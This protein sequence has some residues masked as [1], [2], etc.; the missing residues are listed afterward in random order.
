MAS[1]N[2]EIVNGVLVKYTG[3]DKEVIIPEGVIEI[4]DHCFTDAHFME[5]ITFPSTLKK[6]GYSVV[7]TDYAG[8]EYAL[9]RVN[10]NSLDTWLNIEFKDDKGCLLNVSEEM[11]LYIDGK[12]VTDLVIP[13]KYKTIKAYSFFGYKRLKSVTFEEGVEV[14]EKGAFARSGLSKVTLPNSVTDLVGK[15]FGGFFSSPFQYCSELKEI[16]IPNTLKVLPNYFLNGASIESI[17]LSGGLKE[18]PSGCFSGCKKLKNIN[19]P[20]S[21]HIVNDHAFYGCDSIEELIFP[22]SVTQ[23]GLMS[24]SNIKKI[25]LPEDWDYVGNKH[26][27][28]FENTKLDALEMNEYDNAYYIGSNTNPYQV[29]V[30]A[31]NK[32]IESCLIHQDCKYICGCGSYSLGNMGFYKCNKIKSLIIPNGVKRIEPGALSNCDSLE[33]VELPDS[34]GVLEPYVYDGSPKLKFK[35]FGVKDRII[36]FEKCL[37]Q[38][39]ESIKEVFSISDKGIELTS[40]RTLSNEETITTRFKK[41]NTVKSER[42]IAILSLLINSKEMKEDDYLNNKDVYKVSFPINDKETVNRFILMEEPLIRVTYSLVKSFIGKYF[43]IN[44]EYKDTLLM[45]RC[46]DIDSLREEIE[47]D[48]Q[49]YNLVELGELLK[50]AKQNGDYIKYEKINLYMNKLKNNG[51]WN[52][53]YDEE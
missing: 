10:V 48:Y 50:E 14:I 52:Q 53:Y 32:D 1:S 42:L 36:S 8:Y 9:K 30:S 46:F 19:I 2:F 51:E 49:Q 4:G 24:F 17:E 20:S 23:I 15:R 44:K 26:W 21:V 33:S 31:K 28:L 37:K 29:L 38:D 47:K 40:I 6:V 11:E 41:N 45:N 43:L 35:E 18:I 12:L 27:A 22:N 3:K 13:G 34:F 7:A 25:V 39:D 5:S 16:N